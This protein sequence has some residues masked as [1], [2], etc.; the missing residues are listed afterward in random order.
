[1]PELLN[2][3]V[4]VTQAASESDYTR[5]WVRTLAVARKEIPYTRKGRLILVHL[6]SLLAHKERMEELGPQK[7]AM[8][9]TGEEQDG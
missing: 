1:M 5:K 4:T 8:G 2:E 6:P 3:Y 9:R 7:H